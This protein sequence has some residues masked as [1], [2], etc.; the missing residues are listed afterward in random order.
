MQGRAPEQKQKQKRPPKNKK[1][2]NKTA[3]KSISIMENNTQSTNAD[4][5][6]TA[7]PKGKI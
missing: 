4:L 3:E 2:N 6:I 7:P 5:P 1:Q